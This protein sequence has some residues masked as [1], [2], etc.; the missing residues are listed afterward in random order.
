MR[1]MNGWLGEAASAAAETV[2]RSQHQNSAGAETS[3]LSITMP[4]QPGVTEIPDSE[5]ELMTS[6]PAYDPPDKLLPTPHSLP[7]ASQGV[8]GEAQASAM[9]GASASGESL[10]GNEKTSAPCFDRPTKHTST[11]TQS[12]NNDN[13][14]RQEPCLENAP[15]LGISYQSSMSTQTSSPVQSEP[16]DAVHGIS[17]NEQCIM[18]ADG[19]EE[20]TE[21]AQNLQLTTE[22][23]PANRGSADTA[24]RSPFE[25][26]A[27]R[28][29]I[30]TGLSALNICQ[31]EVDVIDFANFAPTATPPE[32]RKSSKHVKA[33]ASVP[34][35][36]RCTSS[37]L[38]TAPATESKLPDL[39]RLDKDDA[40]LTSHG[41]DPISVPSPP[42]G[43]SL[44]IGTHPAMA[45]LPET[46]LCGAGAK[47]RHSASEADKIKS[48]EK[49]DHASQTAMAP[50]ERTPAISSTETRPA[51]IE[52]PDTTPKPSNPAKSAQE[53]TLAELKAQRRALLA[54]L[55][56]L[57]NIQETINQDAVS[58][59]LEET[60]ESGP[61][62][63]QVMGAAN[64]IV[65][66]HIKLLHEYNEIKD[67]GQGLMGL[68]ADQRGV[69]IIEV[70]DEFGIGEKD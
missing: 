63:E 27:K 51:H 17:T 50:E 56:A 14:Q 62:D 11:D 53:T 35:E 64:K 40:T 9:T 20:T 12:T 47:I 2:R 28:K 34:K 48:N 43:P 66:K 39:T 61:S 13:P 46:S 32:D 59:G 25:G 29:R 52:V 42:S 4:L 69:R 8:S 15:V 31:E 49:E 37:P 38:T 23:E 16:D 65:K 55:A 1:Q 3:N 7:Q 60:S 30:K 26:L 5:D 45:A 21:Q 18:A 54:A 6:S 44:S 36:A 41:G 10:V 67:V 33:K 58:S 70:Q 19:N 24:S 68:I 22:E 57:P